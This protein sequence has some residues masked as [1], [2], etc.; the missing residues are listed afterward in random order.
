M[1]WELIFIFSCVVIHAAQH[2]VIFRYWTV[3]DGLGESFSI[4]IS[5]GPSG[6]VFVTRR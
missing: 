1:A 2:P 4:G 3:A 6:K 5:V